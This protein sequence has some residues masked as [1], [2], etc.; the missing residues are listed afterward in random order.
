M[1]GFIHKLVKSSIRHLVLAVGNV[2]HVRR[3]MISDD[4]VHNSQTL[5]MIIAWIGQSTATIRI[6]DN[7]VRFKSDPLAAFSFRAQRGS[8]AALGTK[9]QQEGQIWIGLPITWIGRRMY[10]HLY[11][12]IRRLVFAVA[13]RPSLSRDRV[14]VTVCH[15][16]SNVWSREAQL[17]TEAFLVLRDPVGHWVDTRY[18][19]LELPSPYDIESGIS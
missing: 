14:C 1:G 4:T 15:R 8:L 12:I 19:I 18:I 9:K 13:D 6:T 17:W 7:L 2:R 16:S 5:M 10:T 11:K 3:Y